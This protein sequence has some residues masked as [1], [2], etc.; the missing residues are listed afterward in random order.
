MET[1]KDKVL[2]SHIFIIIEQY[3]YSLISSLK[4]KNP[5][6]LACASFEFSR[7]ADFECSA[8]HCGTEQQKKS[9]V[10]ERTHLVCT[11]ILFMRRQSC[12]LIQIY[13][14]FIQ[15]IKILF[16][17]ILSYL[18]HNLLVIIKRVFKF[19]LNS[20]GLGVILNI[21]CDTSLDWHRSKKILEN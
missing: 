5:I 17:V 6:R 9:R 3:L 13:L 10:L 16:Y 20:K 15:I 8:K 19:L 7:I 2:K 1:S 18:W 14:Y 12:T 21:P 4:Q 11:V